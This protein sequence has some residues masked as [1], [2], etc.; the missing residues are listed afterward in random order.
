MKPSAMRV[1]SLL[2]SA[3]EIIAAL[4]AM[5]SLVGVT[6][7]CDHPPEVASRARASPGASWTARPP[8]A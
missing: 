5:D 7:E 3:T 6:H 1:V 4:G 8:Q 2:P